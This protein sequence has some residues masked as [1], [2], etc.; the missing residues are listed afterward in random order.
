MEES[1]SLQNRI[2]LAS[3]AHEASKNVE[4]DYEEVRHR[5]KHGIFSLVLITSFFSCQVIKLL[6]KEVDEL[7]QKNSQKGPDPVSCQKQLTLP[8]ATH[9]T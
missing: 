5:S 6:E 4:Q 2:H 7:K 1:R 9:H 8:H 3:Q